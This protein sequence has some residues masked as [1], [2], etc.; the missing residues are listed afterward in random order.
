MSRARRNKTLRWPRNRGGGGERVFEVQV[1]APGLG[2]REGAKRGVW[3]VRPALGGGCQLLWLWLGG[4]EGW[5]CSGQLHP[6]GQWLFPALG[7]WFRSCRGLT[8]F[9]VLSVLLNVAFV[10]DK[11]V[12]AGK[13][14]REIPVT[15]KDPCSV[16]SLE[17]WDQ[18]NSICYSLLKDERTWEQARNRCSKLRASLAMLS[19]EEMDHL[20]SP[21]QDHIFHLNGNLDYWLR[22]RRRGERL[23][24]MDGS[25]YNSS[26][27]VLG[28]SECVYLA[29]CTQE[30]GLFKAAA[31]PL[32]QTPNSLI[33][34]RSEGERTFSIL[35]T[36][37]FPFSTSP[38]M[39]FCR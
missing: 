17:A 37:N 38:G 35:K 14:H 33:C 24:W 13:S 39:S 9:L 36:H 21:S 16:P 5:A 27:E 25:S 31:V 32:Q 18:H 19:D 12:L 15:P 22:L 28:N 23:Q 1:G 8:V 6:H 4:C 29:D 26:L 2:E 34:N 11:I 7:N 10:V 3:R 30:R 20:L